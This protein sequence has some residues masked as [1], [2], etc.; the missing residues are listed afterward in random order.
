MGHILIMSFE[1]IKCF[2]V[3]ELIDF[4]LVCA[5]LTANP[6]VLPLVL[7]SDKFC[8]LFVQKM[9]MNPML[10]KPSGAENSSSQGGKKI[11]KSLKWGFTQFTREEYVRLRKSNELGADGN[12][13]KVHNRRGPLAESVL[14]LSGQD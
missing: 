3:Q 4:L 1:L 13:V 11:L 8:Y 2:H 9:Y 10:S 6:L 5:I 14:Y 12:I 7:I